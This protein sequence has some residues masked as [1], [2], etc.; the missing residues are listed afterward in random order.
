MRKINLREIKTIRH[1]AALVG[2]ELSIDD[3]L[4]VWEINPEMGSIRPN[5]CSRHQRVNIIATGELLDI[6]HTPIVIT[7]FKTNDGKFGE[8]DFWKVTDEP[9]IRHPQD[10]SVMKLWKEESPQNKKIKMIHI[11]KIFNL[12]NNAKNHHQK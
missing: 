5:Y 10:P 3:D 2:E 9:I 1:M 7:L 11:R 8:L 6:D 4:M 12:F